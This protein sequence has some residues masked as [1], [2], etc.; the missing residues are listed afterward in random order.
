MTNVR[1]DDYVAERDE[2]DLNVI[3]IEKSSMNRCMD[4]CGKRRVRW[5]FNRF[6]CYL[7]VV[8]NDKLTHKF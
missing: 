4:L 5:I 6:T 8:E 7:V 1:I 2:C 3:F